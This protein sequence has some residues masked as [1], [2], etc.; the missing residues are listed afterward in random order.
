MQVPEYIDPK[1]EG[2]V[3]ELTI[4]SDDCKKLAE[5]FNTWDD[6]W[7]GGWTGGKP[8]DEKRAKEYIER[9]AAIILLVSETPEG[10]FGGYCSLYERKSEPGVSYV[11]I[12]GANPALHGKKHGKNLLIKAIETA[13]EKGYE[14]VDLHT[15]SSN[16][17][18]VPL[19]KKTGY[20]WVPETSVYMQDFIPKIVKEKFLE[21]FFKKCDYG[22]YNTQVRELTQSDDDITENGMKVFPYEFSHEED[23]IINANEFIY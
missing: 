9:Q 14:R 7:P 3:R 21:P 1:F 13:M 4:S 6:V 20:F 12:L 18:A 19:Y 8:Y 16:M 10:D 2:K 17:E 5:L 11:A 23:I 15:W 22:W